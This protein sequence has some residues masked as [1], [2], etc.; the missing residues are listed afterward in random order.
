[1]DFSKILAI[2]G[3]PGLFKV[4]AQSSN[5]LIVESLLDKKRMNAFSNFKIS[6]L[7]DISVYTTGDDLP[8]MDVFK[9]IREKQNDA[10]IDVPGSD[11]N[12]QRAYF[13][14]V[15]PSFD[16]ERVHNSDIKKIISWYNLLL[17]N[18]MLDFTSP[19]EPVVEEAAAKPA[20]AKTRVAKAPKG[21]GD[22]QAKV[23]SGAKV[24]RKANTPRKTG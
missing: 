22:A 3:Y 19:E 17:Q 21:G 18:N 4:V 23:S 6:A 13:S 1:M 5:G 14:E 15:V 9:S 7:S 2:S 12:A 11:S 8:L 24:A 20:D 10:A 16:Q